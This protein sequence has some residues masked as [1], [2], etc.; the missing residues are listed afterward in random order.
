MADAIP[1]GRFVWFD[2]MT[3][4]QVGAI[5]FYTKIANWGT[6]VWE[7]PSPYTMWTN[8]TT[9]LGGIMPLP[10]EAEAPPHWLAYISSPD[11]DATVAEA[12]GLGAT[13]VVAPNDIPTVGRFAVMSDPQGAVFAIFTPAEGPPGHEGPAAAGEFSWHELMTTDQ[14]AA[15]EF[16]QRLFGWE[17]GQS[18][19]MG[20]VGVY[21]IYGRNGV[22]LGGMFNNPNEQPGG[23]A[24]LHYIMVQDIQRAAEATKEH[25]GQVINGPMEVPG[26]DWIFQAID[27]QG[28]MFAMHARR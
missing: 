2:L 16:Y 10:P 18:V 12:N 24:W 26:G 13:T 23:P 9:A 21:Q 22:D 4:D 15:F 20:P 28:A 11:T 14:A 17:K 25:G 19:D 1:R 7:G 6:T 5:D 3:T 8:G 27:P